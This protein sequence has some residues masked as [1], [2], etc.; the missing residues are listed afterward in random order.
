MRQNNSKNKKRLKIIVALVIIAALCAG[1]ITSAVLISRSRII[2]DVRSVSA[3]STTWW[4]DNSVTDGLV[5]TDVSQS[6]YLSTSEMVDA[7]LVSEGQSVR[8][9]D[10]L[11]EYDT[12]LLAL[13]AEIQELDIELLEGKIKKKQ[14]E[15]DA[16]KRKYSAIISKVTTLS[17]SGLSFGIGTLAAGSVSPAVFARPL[18]LETEPTAP[19]GGLEPAD[20]PQAV[21]VLDKDS[22]PY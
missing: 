4:G 11:I 18:T 7:I 22:V 1:G 21:S 14:T 9:G 15:L 6:I 2:V 16:Y 5:S 12:T 17:A 3:L 10:P 20:D 8:T 13:Q 19:V